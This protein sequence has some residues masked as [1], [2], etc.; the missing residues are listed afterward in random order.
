MY[1]KLII[2]RL[3]FQN[4][5]SSEFWLGQN[6]WKGFLTVK[7][8][9]HLFH[10]KFPPILC[11]FATVSCKVLNKTDRIRHE[12]CENHLFAQGENL[13]LVPLW[14]RR[15]ILTH[16]QTSLLYKWQMCPGTWV[17]SGHAAWAQHQ[18]VSRLQTKAAHVAPKGKK[19]IR[20]GL[21]QI[22]LSSWVTVW[23]AT[24]ST[25]ELISYQNRLFCYITRH[26]WIWSNVRKKISLYLQ[27]QTK[28][29]GERQGYQC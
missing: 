7:I 17:I 28:L 9:L 22:H 19:V 24:K 8:H 29:R 12:H 6:S 10:V 5:C 14:R 25:L 11:V 16:S 15:S 4:F 27:K 20:A 13:F 21:K 1:T 2:T 3:L 26:F 23:F 18:N